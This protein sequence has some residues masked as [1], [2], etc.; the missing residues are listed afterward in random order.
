MAIALA[1]C[2]LP[3]ARAG[4]IDAAPPETKAARESR[5]EMGA[6]GIEVRAHEG[7]FRLRINGKLH[8]DSVRHDADRSSLED[9]FGVRRARVTL[10]MDLS[11][12][13]SSKSQFEFSDSEV[14][15]KDLYVRFSPTKR[16]GATFGQ[17]KEPFSLEQLTGSD[18]LTFI[19]RALPVD[20]L[21]PGRALGASLR[22]SSKHTSITAGIFNGPVVLRGGIPKEDEGLSA[23]ARGT[24]APV[25]TKGRVVHFGLSVGSRQFR[26]G[27]EPRFRFRPE[28]S[29]TD[30]RFVNT[31]RIEG[32]EDLD[33]VGFEVVGARGPLSLQSEYIRTRLKRPLENFGTIEMSG[34]YANLSWVFRGKPRSYESEDGTFGGVTGRKRGPTWEIAARISNLDLDDANIEGGQETNVTIG[35]NWSP[36]PNLRLMTNYVRVHSERRERRDRPSILLARLQLTF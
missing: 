1:A 17:S 7:E 31:G 8:L 15:L 5:F 23:S 3:A 24:W 29:L 22:K 16:I 25:S 14:E 2:L 32:I 19:E 35:L 33:R 12:R 27:A 20:A 13:W 26:E 18:D 36:R 21:A 28:S 4:G 34:W 11:K 6:D 30:V 9:D 10:K